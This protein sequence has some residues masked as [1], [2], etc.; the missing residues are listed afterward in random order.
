[1]NEQPQI[2]LTIDDLVAVK[3]I[4]NIACTRGA[5][6][7]PEMKSVGE[8]YERV[9]AFLNAVAAQAQAQT[10]SQPQGESND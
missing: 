10:D 4:I 3:N 6:Q 2:Q 5:F 9:D 1:M 7:A 8:V